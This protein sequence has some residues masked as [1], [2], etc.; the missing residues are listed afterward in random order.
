MTASPDF[1]PSLRF[2]L[3]VHFGLYSQLGRGEWVMNRE[4]MARSDYRK[5][6]DRFVPSHF[7]AEALAQRAVATG[8]R[9]L[10]FTTMHHDGFRLYHSELTDFCSTKAATGRDF[11]AEILAACRKYGLKVGLYHS[12]NNWMDQP[13]AVDALEDPAA[14]VRFLDATHRRIEELVTRYQPIDILWYDGWWPFNAEGWEA[15]RMN[16]MARRIQPHLLFNGRNGLPGDFATPEQHISPPH[17]WRPWEACVTLNDHWGYHAGDRNWKSPLDLI[18]LLAKTGQHRGN[19]LLNVGPD[20][21][22][23]L[24]AECQALLEKVGRWVATNRESVF[25]TDPWTIAPFHRGNH[26]GDWSDHGIFTAR[27]NHLYLIVTS[28][29]V[30]ELAL[31]GLEMRVEDVRVLGGSQ[32][33][34][35]QT[36]ATLH[37]AL[38]TLPPAG[39]DFPSVLRFTCDGPPGIYLTGGARTPSVTHPRYDPLPSDIT[40]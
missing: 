20:G 37:V 38:D 33:P 4:G 9:Y 26:R 40:W 34:F 35:R 1:F 22:G 11:T 25:E 15:E 6:A 29:P 18:Q 2:G 31:A 3:F 5:L 39:K 21:E 10:V 14:R 19:L 16:A 27:G 36:G 24:P 23:C 8:M 30:G 32:L 17:P 7:D 13:D 28:P 12:L